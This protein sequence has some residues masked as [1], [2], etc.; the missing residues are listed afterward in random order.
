MGE[1][2]GTDP[3]GEADAITGPFRLVTYL[4]KF[5]PQAYFANFPSKFLT[6][7]EATGGVHAYLSYS[8]NFHCCS[9]AT[10]GGP[11]P[12]KP[13]GSGYHWTL[14]QVKLRP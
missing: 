9:N 14:Q 8:A 11:L 10:K 6:P 4:E 7:D 13:R 3:S 12:T 1:L 2:G 5:G